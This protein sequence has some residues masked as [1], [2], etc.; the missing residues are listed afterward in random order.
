MSKNAFDATAIIAK[1][2]LRSSEG[3]YDDES[4]GISCHCIVFFFKL[5]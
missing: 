2:N 1:Q 5:I 4:F 3:R